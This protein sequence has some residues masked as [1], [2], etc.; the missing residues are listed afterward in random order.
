MLKICRGSSV[1]QWSCRQGDCLIFCMFDTLCV[2]SM[3]NVCSFFFPLLARILAWFIAMIPPHAFSVD[4]SII[5]HLFC[6]LFKYPKLDHSLTC[7]RQ[8]AKR[9]ERRL[10][11][12]SIWALFGLENNTTTSF[13]ESDLLQERSASHMGLAT[14]LRAYLFS[15][16]KTFATVVSQWNLLRFVSVSCIPK[17]A[18][19][20]DLIVAAENSGTLLVMQ[21]WIHVHIYIRIV[22]V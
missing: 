10:H 13:P 9:R 8:T 21:L 17:E 14:I 11:L 12:L 20:S 22:P 4:P 18:V 19:P 16:A 15:S 7:A 1:S 5:Y 6:C 2:V 3:F